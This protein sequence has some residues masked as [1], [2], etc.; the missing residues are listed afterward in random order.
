MA[1]I[2]FDDLPA[3]TADVLRRRARSAGLGPAEYVRRELI[4]RARTR[5]S[6]DAVV[7]F[8]E[9]QGCL[10][11]P[12]IDTDAVAVIHSYDMP[13]DVLDRFARRA[14]AT[15]MPIG[16]YMRGQLIAMARRSTVDDAMGEF[17]EAMRAD[18]S[19]DLDMNEIAASVR[20]A[21]GL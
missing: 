12:V 2:D 16:E 10:P 21:R 17:E 6:D 3:A 1:L 11:G 8:V 18:P 9:Q 19:L 13:F 14:S 4:S 7:D 15:G 5:V 20:Y